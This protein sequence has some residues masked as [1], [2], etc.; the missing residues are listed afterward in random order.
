MPCPVGSILRSACRQEGEPLDILCMPTHERFETNLARTGHRFWAI[1]TPQV[2]DWNSRYAAVPDNYVLLNSARGAQQLPPEMDF[3]LV[4]SQNK[5]GQFQ[6]ASDLA[7]ALH[8]PLVSLEHTLPHPSWP[9]AQLEALRRLRGHKNVFI[10]DFSRRAWL[11]PSNEAVVIHHG[12]DTQLFSPNDRLISKKKHVLSVV[13]DFRNRNWCCGY[14]FWEQATSGLPRLHVGDSPDGWSQPARSLA[15]LVLRYREATAFIDT[16][17]AS[18][19]P[20]V[21]LEA[22]SC[23]CVVVSRGNAMVSEVIEDGVNGF[24]RPEA[25]AARALLAD[26]LARPEAYEEVRQRARQTI[27]ERFA[28][29]AFIDNWDRLLRQAAE[30]PFLGA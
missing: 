8:L 22:M 30:V 19:I 13:N 9:V 21:V 12:V 29:G 27:L 4:L 11:W 2:K 18:P 14:N 26:I 6:I 23:G 15:E 25:T 10:S 16:A 1:R 7:R 5:F 20:T 3:D 17:S 28:L 24:L